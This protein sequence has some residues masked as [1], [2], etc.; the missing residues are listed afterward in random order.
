MSQRLLLVVFCLLSLPVNK[1][2]GMEFSLGGGLSSVEEGDDRHRPAIVGHFGLGGNYF[3]HLYYYARKSGP[4][5]ERTVIISANYTLD[6]FRQF[7]F[8]FLK[9]NLGLCAMDEQTEIKFPGDSEN[10][11]TENSGNL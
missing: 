6:L 5:T 2:L 10:S 11:E 8:D 3:S 1:A 7:S 9:A 4:V